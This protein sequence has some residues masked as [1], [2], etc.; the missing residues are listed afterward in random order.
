MDQ[1][2]LLRTNRF[3]WLVS[4]VLLAFTGL[5]GYRCYRY[6]PQIT[7]IYIVRH[8]ERQDSSSNSPLSPAG[9]ARANTL[10]HVLKDEGIAAIFV[11]NLQRTQ[12]TAAPLA[13]A[14]GLTPIEY[15]ATVPQTAVDEVLANHTGGRILI[16]GH[17]DTVDDIAAGLGAGGLT[18]L[19]GTQF[20]RLFVVHRVA[21]VAHLDRLRYGTETP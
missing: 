16:V 12:Q 6:P 15:P 18:D 5:I 13:A 8:A 19:A 17:S 14:T 7:T 21:N 9:H 1:T 3:A 4:A 2:P 20:D 11:T 10:T